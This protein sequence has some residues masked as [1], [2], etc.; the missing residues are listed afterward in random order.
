MAHV[1][2]YRMIPEVLILLRLTYYAILM[3]FLP[4]MGLNHSQ[5]E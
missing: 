4:L 2:I 5:L 1:T 3:F